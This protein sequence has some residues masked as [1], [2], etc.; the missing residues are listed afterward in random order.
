MEENA[1]EIGRERRV[2]RRECQN[3]Q[4]ENSGRIFRPLPLTL[5]RRECQ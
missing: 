2:K 1:S 5:E 4:E 3:V